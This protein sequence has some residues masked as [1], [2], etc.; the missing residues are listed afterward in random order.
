MSVFVSVCIILGVCYSYVPYN[1]C[2]TYLEHVIK[3][4]IFAVCILVF[5]NW[6]SEKWI[7]TERQYG[8]V[9][10]WHIFLM[11][12]GCLGQCLLKGI[13]G[14]SF[15]FLKGCVANYEHITLLW[16]YLFHDA[17]KDVTGIQEK[18]CL[19][20]CGAVCNI[21]TLL[22][23]LS[24]SWELDHEIYMCFVDLGKVPNGHL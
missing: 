20:G 24:R 3:I 15:P 5:W 16:K 2:P 23:L 12:C 11:S 9:F 14:W 18:Q 7:L 19:T 8:T 6:T 4:N 10:G 13:L 1:I 17:E 22:E 21:F